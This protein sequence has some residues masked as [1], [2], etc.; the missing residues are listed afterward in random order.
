MISDMPVKSNHGRER[1]LNNYRLKYMHHLNYWKNNRQKNSW[2]V[3][4]NPSFKNFGKI[5][6]FIET[7]RS[8]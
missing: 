5:E 1:S 8:F 6:I 4:E 7:F 3:F 2:V